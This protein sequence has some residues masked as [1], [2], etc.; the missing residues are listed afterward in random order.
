MLVA[1]TEQSGPALC[2]FV[3]WSWV[4][5][6]TWRASSFSFYGC[7]VFSCLKVLNSLNQPPLMGTEV[8]FHAFLQTRLQGTTLSLRH[9]AYMG[10]YLSAD[11]PA[12]GSAF[13]TL[14]SFSK[15]P[16]TINVCDCCC[17]TLAKVGCYPKPFWSLPIGENGVLVY[18]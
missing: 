17:P 9:F 13:V 16:S 11:F 2:F 14:M 18:F 8:V 5:A 6:A 10:V 4:C 1:Y 12:V 3:S 7:R 15:L